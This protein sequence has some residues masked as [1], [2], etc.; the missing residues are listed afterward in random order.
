MRVSS[1]TVALI[2]IALLALSNTVS[3]S[4]ALPAHKPTRRQDC[5]SICDLQT[6]K[7]SPIC[8]KRGNSDQYSVFRNNCEMR[9]HNCKQ[10]P[11]NQYEY[12]GPAEASQNGCRKY[13]STP[14]A[15]AAPGAVAAPIPVPT[16]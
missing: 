2:S 3:A 4:P 1:I 9:I 8:G 13:Q 6:T 15:P 16:A 10:S 7:T 11:E 14:I 12:M 5:N